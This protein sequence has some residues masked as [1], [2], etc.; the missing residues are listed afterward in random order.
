[1]A[2]LLA[3]FPPTLSIGIAHYRYSPPLPALHESYGFA[4]STGNI[5]VMYN[6]RAVSRCRRVVPSQERFTAKTAPPATPQELVTRALRYIDKDGKVR[7][8]IEGDLIISEPAVPVDLDTL[9]DDV[10]RH[11]LLRVAWILF[12]Q[13]RYT[14]TFD[15]EVLQILA[16]FLGAYRHDPDFLDL[17][18]S[19]IHCDG[20]AW[21]SPTL[22]DLELPPRPKSLPKI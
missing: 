3:L 11:T 20:Q 12:R 6:S 16:I 5:T 2:T 13:H 15:E 9:P 19:L 17:A 7:R 10:W 22:R 21:D 14:E 8:V 18:C 1:V 4:I